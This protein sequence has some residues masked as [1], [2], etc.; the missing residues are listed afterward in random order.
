MA[1]AVFSLGVPETTESQAKKWQVNKHSIVATILEV[2]TINSIN[3]IE[4]DDNTSPWNLVAVDP[5]NRNEK[6]LSIVLNQIA[7]FVLLMDNCELRCTIKEELSGK[8]RTA[9]IGKRS[10]TSI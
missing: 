7:R 3:V 4:F 9:I 10:N 1:D 6:D 5:L 2:L 8:C